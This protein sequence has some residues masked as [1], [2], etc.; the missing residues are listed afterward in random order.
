[1]PRMVSVRSCNRLSLKDIVGQDGE[2]SLKGT[3]EHEQPSRGKMERLRMPA[4]A[5]THIYLSS[6]CYVVG[7]EFVT[8]INDEQP[9]AG[10]CF[11]HRLT[12]APVSL[13]PW[14]NY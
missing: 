12:L 14:Y 13:F 7:M 6:F 5:T 1:M 10:V 4:A 8:K 9:R 2:K 11:L 3:G